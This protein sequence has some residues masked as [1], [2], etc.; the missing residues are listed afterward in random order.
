M[1]YNK[2]NWVDG[3]TEL[4]A[5]HL[6]NIEEGIAQVHAFMDGEARDFHASISRRVKAWG[7]VFNPDNG[8][9]IM[10]PLVKDFNTK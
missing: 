8:H 7:P 4:N 3:K 2:T 1:S 9:V 10:T 5:S 6:N